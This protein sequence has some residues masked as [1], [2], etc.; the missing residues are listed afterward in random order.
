MNEMHTEMTCQFQ[1]ALSGIRG[2]RKNR[3]ARTTP[4]NTIRN[5]ATAITQQTTTKKQKNSWIISVHNK[6]DIPIACER[7]GNESFICYIYE[8]I[9][10]ENKISSFAVLYTQFAMLCTDTHTNTHKKKKKER[11]KTNSHSHSESY[12]ITMNIY[13]T[14]RR[15]KTLN[16][17]TDWYAT[18]PCVNCKTIHNNNQFIPHIRTFERTS[19]ICIVC[20]CTIL[21]HAQTY[22]RPEPIE[23]AQKKPR[24]YTRQSGKSCLMAWLP[25]LVL[26]TISPK[27]KS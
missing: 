5:K 22:T 13:I 11:K 19:R 4:I 10:A 3:R 8:C 25:R 12:C 2:H 6:S 27:L 24:K 15:V 23:A 17:R 26:H 20:W 1:F 9:N 7:N 14:T 18:Q 21:G 16:G